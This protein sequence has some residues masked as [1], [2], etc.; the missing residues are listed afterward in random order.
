VYGTG[1]LVVWVLRDSSIHV[2]KLGMESLVDSSVK[3]IAIANPIHAPYG[4]AAMDA[5]KSMGVYDQVKERIVFGDSVLQAA[6]FVENGGAD[7]GLISHSFA[8]APMFRDKGRYWEVPA[9]AYPRREQ[10]GVILSWAHDKSAAQA[11]RDFVLGERGKPILRSYGFG[12]S[13]E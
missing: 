9:A 10:G 5:M 4:R 12:L 3:K 11:F 13:G 8:L 2:E 7:I 6:Q 1:R